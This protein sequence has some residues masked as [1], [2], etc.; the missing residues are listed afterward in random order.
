MR[1]SSDLKTLQFSKIPHN[2]RVLEEKK[3]LAEN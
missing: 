1:Q 3:N 2:A